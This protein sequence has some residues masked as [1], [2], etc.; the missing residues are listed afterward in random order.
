MKEVE[1]CNEDRRFVSNFLIGFFNSEVSFLSE[2]ALSP[3]AAR[4]ALRRLPDP[5][6]GTA[7]FSA[8]SATVAKVEQVLASTLEFDPKLTVLKV[9]TDGTNTVRGEDAPAARAAV[10][11]LHQAGGVV[12]LL[13]AGDDTAAAGLLGIPTD[14]LLNWSDNAASLAIATRASQ[15]ATRLFRQNSIDGLRGASFVYTRMQRL[16]SFSGRDPPPRASSPR[17]RLHPAAAVEDHVDDS[18]PRAEA[19]LPPPELPLPRRRAIQ[20][21]VDRRGADFQIQPMQRMN[22]LPAPSAIGVRVVNVPLP[23]S[24]AVVGQALTEP[25]PVSE[26]PLVQLVAELRR[27]IGLHDESTMAQVVDAACRHLGVAGS[28]SGGEESAPQSMG[29]K[30]RAAACLAA[31][32]A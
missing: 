29:L 11:R 7:L 5:S 14:T 15:D 12:S 31:I 24:D 18:P 1:G 3:E 19:L 16:E 23:T 20:I 21:A 6:G 2:D 17:P 26:M 13:Q 32:R 30:E 22:S 10:E 27:E 8:V 9:L 25:M 28:A 4:A